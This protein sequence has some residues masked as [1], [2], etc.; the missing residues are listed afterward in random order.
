MKKLM[1]SII[2]CI[3]SCSVF[4]A[5]LESLI[6][7][8]KVSDV[9]DYLKVRDSDLSDK[10]YLSIYL[11]HPAY[12]GYGE[13]TLEMVDF[14]IKHKANVNSVDEREISPIIYAIRDYS[15][16]NTEILNM[17]LD[18]GAKTNQKYSTKFTFSQRLYNK[19]NM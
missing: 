6:A 18:S 9:E 17:L 14:L 1:L 11:K 19:F 16:Y 8:N 10:P 4:G 13:P 2:I 12:N 15:K 5:D 3:I 7:A